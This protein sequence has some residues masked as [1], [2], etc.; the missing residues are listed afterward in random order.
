MPGPPP[1]R[2]APS[3]PLTRNPAMDIA[4]AFLADAR[5]DFEKYRRLAE[6]AVAHVAESRW[7]E[8]IDPEANSVALVMKHMAGNLRSRWTDFLTTDGEKADRARDTEFEDE[9]ADDPAAIRAR[10]DDGWARLF[11]AI[12]PLGPADLARTVTIR[13]EPHTVM[14]AIQR[15]LTHYAYHVGQIVFIAKHLAGPGWASLSIPRG[16]SA[17][18]DATQARS[19][20]LPR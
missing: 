15:Q 7:F 13:G 16:R 12:D 18:F 17:G 6:R 10:W 3:P 9:A 1:V 2:F 5:R 20:Y 4:A 8:R 11:A 19:S 14:Q